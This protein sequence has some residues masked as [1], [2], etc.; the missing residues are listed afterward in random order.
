[1]TYSVTVKAIL[2]KKRKLRKLINDV[3]IC[4]DLY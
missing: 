2:K 4:E 3:Y 1:M